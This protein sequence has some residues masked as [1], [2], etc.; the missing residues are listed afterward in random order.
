MHAPA[1]R[2]PARHEHVLAGDLAAPHRAALGRPGSGPDTS[3]PSRPRPD[4]RLPSPRA[5]TVLTLALYV[6]EFGGFV[7]GM[8]LFKYGDRL[9]SLTPRETVWVVLPVASILAVGACIVAGWRRLGSGRSLVIIATN[10]VSVV[11]VLALAEG[12]M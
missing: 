8:A 1:T 3:D 12:L 6:L 10:L 5:A 9:S 11:I 4:Q 7:L 2:L